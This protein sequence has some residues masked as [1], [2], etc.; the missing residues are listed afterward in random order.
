MA[1]KL[2]A[3]TLF[4]LTVTVHFFTPEEPV[5]TPASSSI[6]TTYSMG[7]DITAA[8]ADITIVVDRNPKVQQM[9]VYG[10]SSQP[11]IFPVSTG[12]FEFEFPPFGKEPGCTDTPLSKNGEAFSPIITKQ[13]HR[14]GRWQHDMKDADGK[15]MLD[16]N[17]VPMMEGSAM[18]YSTFITPAIAL[19]VAPPGT[20]AQIGTKA[21][22][23]CIRMNRA[24]AKEIFDA[25]TLK[26]ADGSYL[27]VDPRNSRAC[28]ADPASTAV[29]T[30]AG[31]CNDE[32]QWEVKRKP[33]NVKVIVKDSSPIEDQQCR[34]MKCEVRK[35]NFD[36]NKKIC[37][38]EKIRPL[39][40]LE[41][42]RQLKDNTDF[43]PKPYVDQLP[44]ADRKAMNEA[45][46]S[47]LKAKHDKAPFPVNCAAPVPMPRP[48]RLSDGTIRSQPAPQ[49]EIPAVIQPRQ[50]VDAPVSN[51]DL[52]GLYM[53]FSNQN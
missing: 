43:N 34:Q 51:D 22:G 3:F 1:K 48:T 42:Q 21:S 9:K 6:E 20:E 8:S 18:E 23:G 50:E 27:T 14:S 17:G 24:D 40:N 28:K 26:K 38:R 47:E 36:W 33:L 7:D 15:P 12:R 41:L 4:V 53:D 35:A 11:K 29:F 13:L 32:K 49:N 5:R 52:E 25:L 19:H 31:Y 16:P 44:E 45:C 46:N 30:P 10:L 2:T 39:L 37:M